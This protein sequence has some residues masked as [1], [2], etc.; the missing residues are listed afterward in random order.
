LFGVRH[1]IF[2]PFFLARFDFLPS[3]SFF[4]LI[5][6]ILPILLILSFSS[7][8]SVHAQPFRVVGTCWS[9][10]RNKPVVM[11]CRAKKREGRCPLG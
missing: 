8:T 6:L 5:L 2:W 4:F 10:S 9:L 1:S 11:S 3:F 7:P